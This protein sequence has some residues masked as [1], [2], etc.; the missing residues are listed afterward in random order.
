M[1]GLTIDV[2]SCCFTCLIEHLCVGGNVQELGWSL[3]MLN[4]IFIHGS[5]K[6]YLGTLMM[7]LDDLVIYVRDMYFRSSPSP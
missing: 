2:G 3:R 4:I 7:N 6:R 5:S 1:L